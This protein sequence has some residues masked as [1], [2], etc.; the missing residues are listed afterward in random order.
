MKLK[1]TLE[2]WTIQDST[3]LY[4]IQS[5]GAGYFRISEDG[6][7]TVNPVL[8]KPEL[9]VSLMDIVSG[10]VERG[11]E[12]PVLLRV[13]NIL[14]SQ[15]SQLHES[16]RAAIKQNNYQGDFKG[17]YP[18][19]VN[20]QQQVIEAIT[21]FG[22]R[23]HHGL[24]AGS[25]AELIAALS[26][27]EDKEACLICNGYKDKDF[28]DL[29]LYA[30][31]M[32]FKCF[33]VV[34][35][36]R[37]V[38]LILERSRALNI[39]PLIGVRFKLSTQAGGHWTESGGDR[40]IF[41]LNT[42][43]I[44][45]V[46]EKIKENDM[47]DCLQL[48]H[49]HLGSQIPNIRDIRSAVLEA[50]RVYSG[51]VNEGAAMK[52]FDIGGGLAVDY[53]GS[54]TNFTNSRNYTLDEYCSDIIESIMSTLDEEHVAHPTI[55]TESGRATVA[56]YSV[57]LFNILDVNRVEDLTLPEK[58][59]EDG[60]EEIRNLI[61]VLNTLSVKNIQECF[62]DAIYYRDLVRQLFRH[63][64][65]SLRERSLA[66]KIFWHIVKK[67]SLNIENMKY[68]PKDL[69]SI[70][71]ALSDTYYA[72]FSVFQSLPDSW[73]I[74]HLFPVMPIHRL[75]EMPT[76]KAILADITCDC[77]G[78]IDR[79]IDMHGVRH[80]LS[81][82]ELQE[83]KDYYLGVFLVGAYQETL[84]DLHNLFGD[85]NVV[86]IRVEETGEYTF[87]REQE[88]D[89][90]AD[91]LSYVEFDAKNMVERVRKTAEEAVQEKRITAQDRRDIMRAYEDGLR[92]YTYFER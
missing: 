41:G 48:L 16:F 40:S 88:G 89:S 76:C 8:D 3:D 30:G 31:K 24:E 26:L 91:V 43:Q 79:F 69:E 82:H 57:L 63:G 22:A 21:R 7:V 9:S 58:F 59:P 83:N 86:S 34:E 19:K 10:I 53:D 50:C 65:I 70:D 13:E 71:V 35:I 5:W 66:E 47:L 2:R 14:E 25:K 49:Y 56:Y 74:G 45:E 62:N 68:V 75:D 73:A 85:T 42:T 6:N 15:I 80:A 18:I 64:E 52:Y 44:V 54:H 23:Y 39:R 84:G 78:K 55:I 12:M 4:Q 38:D 92:G 11:Y 28:V 33:F 61:E 29:G 32:G 20:Q 27:L 81:V 60:P 17:V 46:I 77:D 90:V 1:S 36:P 37:E 72:N 51:M 67:I 87:V